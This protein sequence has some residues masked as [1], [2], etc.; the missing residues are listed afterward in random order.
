MSK[1]S[2]PIRVRDRRSG[3]IFDEQ[4]YGEGA[5]R[6]VYG[7]PVGLAL[8]KA[9]LSKR[10]VSALMGAYHDSSSSTAK[11]GSFI[12]RY[13]INMDEFE[14]G[15]FS[16]FNEFF[17]RRFKLNARPFVAAPAMAAFAEARYFAWE[18]TDESTAVPVK[19][20]LLSPRQLL[21]DGISADQ[22][23]RLEGGPLLL[24]RLCP[25]DYHRFHFPDHGR[26]LSC[27]RIPGRLHS[28]NPVA[29]QARP[30]TF[31]DNE[32][33]VSLLECDSLG[34]LAYVEVGA[35]GVGK[36]IQRRTERF[37]RGAEKG[38]FLFGGSTVIVVGEPGRWKPDHDLLSATRDGIET[39]IHLGE[40]IADSTA[41]NKQA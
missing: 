28:V 25:T 20:A 40:K 4:V 34:M 31:L 12:S 39:L 35:L 23:R 24:A 18:Q 14:A 19:G 22:A 13:G 27:R 21:S 5:L 37:E 38:Y 29:L 9:L 33:Q 10:L 16:S 6:W 30:R 8:E 7:S 26:W 1:T 2:T 36:I 3:K 17:I 15:P 41:G 32:R 11:I